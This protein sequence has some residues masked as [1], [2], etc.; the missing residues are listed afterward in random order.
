MALPSETSDTRHQF[1]RSH[2]YDMSLTVTAPC[3]AGVTSNT[4]SERQPCG[5][6]ALAGLTT[7]GQLA[8]I[9]YIT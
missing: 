4:V 8:M 9:L 2:C 1:T 5:L 3:H 7:I 6:L